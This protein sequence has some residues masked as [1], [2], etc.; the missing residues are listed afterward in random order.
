LSTIRRIKDA[1]LEQALLVWLRSRVARYGEV[2]WIKLDTA[3]RVLSAELQLRGDP[4]VVTISEARYRIES[5]A[6]ETRMVIHGIKISREWAQNL[7][8]DFFRELPVKIPE[9]VKP[10]VE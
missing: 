6:G 5:R 9:F 8:D 1:A 2:R 3:E 10:L 7:I 4:E